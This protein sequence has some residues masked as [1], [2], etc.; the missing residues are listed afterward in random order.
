MHPSAAA[1]APLHTLCYDISNARE[2]RRVDKLLKGYGVRAQ[3]SVFEC[4]LTPSQRQS[5]LSALQELALQTGQVRMYRVYADSS[6]I[7]SGVGSG[8][9]VQQVFSY[10]IWWWGWLSESPQ[11]GTMQIQ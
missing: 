10:G 3:K 1:E 11:R 7:L 8:P 9:A 4:H 2:R 6:P 5:L